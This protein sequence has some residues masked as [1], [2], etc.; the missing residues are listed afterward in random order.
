MRRGI[1]G[2]IEFIMVDRFQMSF[3]IFDI[4]KRIERPKLTWKI[5]YQIEMGQKYGRIAPTIVEVMNED[6]GGAQNKARG[7]FRPQV[8]GDL[9][10]Y[11][12]AHRSY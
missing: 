2:R 12:G 8:H 4:K 5:F 3:R 6:A 1:F 10:A 7:S 9:H 11:A